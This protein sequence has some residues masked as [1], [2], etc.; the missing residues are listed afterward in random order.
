L[1]ECAYP[2]SRIVQQINSKSRVSVPCSHL[3]KCPKGAVSMRFLYL[4]L[5]LLN[6]AQRYVNNVRLM[7][8]NN[9]HDIDQLFHGVNFRATKFV[10]LADGFRVG[11]SGNNGF[12]NA[13]GLYIH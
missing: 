1:K 8:S 3:G 13:F 9:E 4:F 12:S 5:V 10:S 7:S 11:N 2:V 6:S